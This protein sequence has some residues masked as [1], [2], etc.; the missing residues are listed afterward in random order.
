MLLKL[1]DGAQPWLTGLDMEEKLFL[2]VFGGLN[3]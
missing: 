2:F 3:E 1:K